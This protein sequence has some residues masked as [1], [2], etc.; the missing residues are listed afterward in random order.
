MD[1]PLV[2]MQGWI[3]REQERA[4]VREE[5]ERITAEA[6]EKIEQQRREQHAAARERLAASP[7]V[8][9]PE[10][11]LDALLDVYDA[12]QEGFASMESYITVEAW[13]SA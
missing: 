5:I 1:Q 6:R 12:D 7:R 10:A 4:R 11:L 9:V 8:E 3:E 13:R 2:P